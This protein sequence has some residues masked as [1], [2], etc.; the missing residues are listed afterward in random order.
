MIINKLQNLKTKTQKIVMKIGKKMY[1][2]IVRYDYRRLIDIK[3]H[4]RIIKENFMYLG[5]IIKPQS[6]SLSWKQTM[7]LAYR[8]LVKGRS[9]MAVT[10][11]GVAVGIGA[12]V[13]LVSFGY[14]LQG[15]VTQKIIWP[16]ALRVA[17]VT[18][19]SSK[20]KINSDVLGKIKVI[21][22]VEK[23][24]QAINLAGQVIYKNSKVDTVVTGL[25]NNYLAMADI[26]IV[27]GKNFSK[28]ADK[29]YDGT[30]DIQELLN[31]DATQKT[32]GEVA[33]V[34]T[35]SAM[36]A[37]TIDF[38]LRDETYIPAYDAPA[39]TGKMMGW[40]RGSILDSYRGEVAWGGVYDD[41]SGLG[42]VATNNGKLQGKWIKAKMP[43]RDSLGDGVYTDVKEE[44][45]VYLDMK[46]V[47]VLSA[48]DKDIE[49][50]LESGQGMVLGTATQSAQLV[51]LLEDKKKT[52]T[53]SNNVTIKVW[54]GNKKEIIV[55]QAL[56]KA[57]N[58]DDKKILGS[59][60]E[61]SYLVTSS[62]LPQISGRVL[63]EPEKYNVVG[64]YNDIK[65]PVIL[66]PRA[67][68]ESLGIKEY[69]LV[70]VMAKT[71][72][73]LPEVRSL[74]QSM[75][76]TTRSVV[77]TLAQIAKLFAIIRFLLG[78]FG[79]IALV[80]ALLGMFNTLTVSLLE[81]TREI[82]VMKSMGTSNVDVTRL[83]LTEAVLILGVG[84]IGG[85]GLGWVIGGILNRLVFNSTQI[86]QNLFVMNGWFSVGILAA[87]L[88]LGVITGWYPAKRASQ[89]SALNALKY[90]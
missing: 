41:S 18:S 71:E 90:E 89:I 24:D 37:E 73:Q 7:W 34:A 46:N 62:V 87:S 57:W 19:E 78:S 55:S 59:E 51:T 49:K 50:M 43:I 5:K 1:F 53:V 63:S 12:V 8:N 4:I 21:P 22:G 25:S 16:D 14:G 61:V 38:R 60:V 66:V 26:K 68:L 81:R 84:G 9:K 85:L 33:G 70:R 52:D 54:Q 86:G 67:D 35:E 69:S 13:L 64:V 56:V 75:G 3:S 72:E 32:I 77:D 44:K 31:K 88:I 20:V 39:A 74:I 36:P 42:R 48:V 58:S 79:A 11:G 83:L 30:A 6:G 28:E 10:V 15:V 23:V 47:N 65:K 80:V 29:Q 82:G 40:I 45:E 17:E 76:L 27:T 2:G